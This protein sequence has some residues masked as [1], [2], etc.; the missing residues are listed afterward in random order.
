MTG[1]V[2]HS[3]RNNMPLYARR[4]LSTRRDVSCVDSGCLINRLLNVLNKHGGSSFGGKFAFD[5]LNL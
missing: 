5:N 1:A 3:R 2:S 4:Y